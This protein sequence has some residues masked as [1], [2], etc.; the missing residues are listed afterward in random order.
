[1]R[2]NE[3]RF[4]ASVTSWL[5]GG[6]LLVLVALLVGF[7]PL[8][9]CPRCL[10]IKAMLDDALAR[11]GPSGP[12]IVPPFRRCRMR[13]ERDKTTVFQK[14]RFAIAEDVQPGDYP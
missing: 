14:W 9:D 1:M 10:K 12:I 6:I 8:A 11:S 7:V 13:S 4:P 5:V 2:T 3:G